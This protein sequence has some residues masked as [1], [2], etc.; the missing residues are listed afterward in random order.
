MET[1]SHS[2]Q[3]GRP[4]PG[5]RFNWRAFI[6]VTTALSF[7]AMSITGVV[8]FVTPPGRVA[9]WTD[10]RMLALTKDQWGGLHIWFSLIF[11][12]AALFH[13][14]LN[15]RSFL[16]YFRS[17]IRKAFA[18]RAEWAIA[19][20]LCGG[21]GWATLADVKPFSSLL[22][23]N[24]AIKNSWETPV[25]RAPIPHAELLT[26]SE[27]AQKTEGLETESMIKN[28][29]AAGIEVESPDVV[30]ENLARKTDM[31]PMQLYAIAAGQSGVPRGGGGRGAGGQ[32]GQGGS[33]MGQMTLRQYCEQ[34]NLDLDK[35]IQKL[36][37]RGFKAELDMTIREIAV[38][39][40]VHPSA[41]RDILIQ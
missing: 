41:M 37:E 16:S 39:G 24:E 2:Q 30:L 1:E 17:R 9:H 32:G 13:L 22:T 23:W 5:S 19:L 4:M 7:V 8:L 3:E 36:R 40:G 38:T 25:G 29:R 28:L 12:I 14:Y 11:M 20:L 33:G 15:W 18:L 31:T 26:L 10:W 27:L 6:S 34:Q 21:I 35:A